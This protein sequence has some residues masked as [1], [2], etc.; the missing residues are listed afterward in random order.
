MSSK[1]T[2]LTSPLII[3]GFVLKNR[4][5]ASNST[6]HFLQ[7]P[8]LYPADG[9]FTHYVNR[10]KGG[11]SIVTI[12]GIN[13][14]VGMPKMDASKDTP[15]FPQFDLYD[16]QCQNYLVQLTEAVHFYGA[17][18]SA[19]L[20]SAFNHFP[21]RSKNGTMTVINALCQNIASGKTTA[22]GASITDELS[23]EDLEKT[24]D[25]IAQQA[26]D[27]K[28]LGFDMVTLHM[29]Y[30]AQIMGEMLSADKNKRTDQY[31]GFFENR[32][33]YPLLVLKRTREAVGEH[34]LIE[35]QFSIEAPGYTQ[36]E[37]LAF[38]KQADPYIDIVQ[39]RTSDV[40]ENHPISY[41]LK[42]NPF[43]D[44]AEIVKKSGIHAKVASVG[45]YQDPLLSDQAISEGKMDLAAMARAWISNPG[46]A[47]LVTAGKEDDIIP[48]L[49]CNKCHG[50]GKNDILASICSVNPEIGLEHHMKE[51]ISLPDHQKKV[52]IIGGGPAGMCCALNLQKR[53]HT[54]VIFESS[55]SLGGAIKHAEYADFKWTLK[56]YKDFLIYQV[57]KNG[58]EVRLNTKADPQSIQQEGFDAVVTALG[59]HPVLPKIPGLLEAH[60]YFYDMVF[61]EPS[62]LGHH[63]II[64]GG[65]EVGVEMGIYLSRMG[66]ETTVLEMRD[67]LAA[68]A[69][70]VHYWKMV[71]NA[72]QNEDNFHGITNAAVTEVK[73]H[74]VCYLDAQQQMHELP[75]DSIAVAAGMASYLKEALA[76]QQA[77]PQFFLIGDCLKPQTIQQAVR[78]AY[79]IAAQ[80]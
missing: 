71:R 61:K 16:A 10:A 45:G 21:Y 63:V 37:G 9:L 54:P 48:C 20:F 39:V 11:A 46:Y 36:Q 12:T 29:A 30:N 35:L 4:M 27:L 77:A 24:A 22:M 58:I 1:Y 66:H 65:G 53:G 26:A 15:H 78:M 25:S 60:P 6:P 34:F 64:I 41:N 73:D 13:N 47:N 50:R 42:K 51:M 44:L 32:C 49:R 62:S 8:E 31:G 14:N 57:H 5:Y 28:K 7:G 52:A 72:W 3:R 55:D 68:D 19:G 23:V 18:I 74:A 75:Y 2:A 40:N 17:L 80:I 69:A 76:F 38:L 79:G 70:M 67:M 33:R 59:A 56:E 43:L